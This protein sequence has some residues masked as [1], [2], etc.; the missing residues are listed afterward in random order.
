MA[1]ALILRCS[2][3]PAEGPISND[4]GICGKADAESTAE[5]D[6]RDWSID[7]VQGIVF[8]STVSNVT[9]WVK[10]SMERFLSV[11]TS[12]GDLQGLHDGDILVNVEKGTSSGYTSGWVRANWSSWTF[13]AG[14]YKLEPSGLRQEP[15]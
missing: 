14:L 2:T 1:G 12:S 4:T 8:E 3:S 7:E 5:C 6:N 10:R 9:G 13:N 15:Y 11:N